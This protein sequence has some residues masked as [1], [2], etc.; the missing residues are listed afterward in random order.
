MYILTGLLESKPTLELCS[1]QTVGSFKSPKNYGR[2]VFLLVLCTH[3][4]LYHHL[5]FSQLI[6]D[7]KDGGGSFGL[8]SLHPEHLPDK[9]KAKFEKIR[10]KIPSMMYVE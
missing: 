10:V 5:F 1:V 2:H 3:V 9:D 6:Y 7:F 4:L 8:L